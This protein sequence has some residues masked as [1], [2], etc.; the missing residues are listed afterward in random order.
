VSAFQV[1]YTSDAWANSWAWPKQC[2]SCAR[3]EYVRARADA[4]DTSRSQRD[5]ADALA[6]SARVGHRPARAGRNVLHPAFVVRLL[7]HS[8]EH[9]PNAGVLRSE[10]DQRLGA[11]GM[12]LEDAIR[13]EG[14]DQA[15]SQAF[16]SSLFGSLH[17]ISTF[18][19]TEFFESVSL[20][21]QILQ[22]DPVV[23]TA[24]WIS[25]AGIAIG[26]R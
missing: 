22:R 11:S 17:L 19:W 24:A 9:E 18:D 13:A 8:R 14:R 3:I 2:S 23:C 1:D 5:R 25:A 15:T 21:E 20:V 26:T 6:A 4:L 10:L 16:M 12:T 7:H